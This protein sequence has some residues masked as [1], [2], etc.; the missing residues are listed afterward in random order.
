MLRQ[1]GLGSD[2]AEVSPVSKPSA[3]MVVEPF[4]GKR[5]DRECRLEAPAT[6]AMT[7][8]RSNIEARIGRVLVLMVPPD[9]GLSL[10]KP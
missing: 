4:E 2:Q 8:I 3:K 1:S 5:C 6:S 9:V 7:A 10:V